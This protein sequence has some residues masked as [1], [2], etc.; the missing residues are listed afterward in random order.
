MDSYWFQNALFW[1]RKPF[2]PFPE[3]DYLQWLTAVDGEFRAPS[4]SSKIE[5]SRS[6]FRCMVVPQRTE[7]HHM[8]LFLQARI[9][10][11]ISNHIGDNC[12]SHQFTR[13]HKGEFTKVER[14]HKREFTRIHT[15]L[16]DS[17]EFT[18]NAFAT[19]NSRFFSDS[20]EFTF[21]SDSHAR[22]WQNYEG[23]S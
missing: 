20:Q 14:I 17:Q 13:I 6:S 21:F 2:G 18:K 11:S 19:K 12:E 16:G 22:D 15:F 7:N 1:V 8:L 9:A 10:F 23:R 5:F 3:T 4:D